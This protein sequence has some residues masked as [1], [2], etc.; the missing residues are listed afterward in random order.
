MFK[1]YIQTVFTGHFKSGAEAMAVVDEP[2]RPFRHSWKI[3]DP[4]GH[5]YAEG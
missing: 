3:L 5:V 2:A 1:L 4:F